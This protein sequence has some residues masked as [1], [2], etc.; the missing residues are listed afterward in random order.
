[1]HDS[2]VKIEGFD[3]GYRLEMP[4]EI[5]FALD[6]DIIRPEAHALIRS[7]AGGLRGEKGAEIDVNGYTDTS[8]TDE[9]NDLLSQSRAVAVADALVRAGVAPDRINPRGFGESLLAVPTPDGVREARNRRV[10]IVVLP[11]EG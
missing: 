11:K 6:S 2:R 8:G 10:E 1:M 7:V 5:L 9:H 4:G 3:K